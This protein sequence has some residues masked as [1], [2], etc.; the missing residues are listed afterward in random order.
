M[1]DDEVR[2]GT[3]VVALVKSSEPSIE[4]KLI[5]HVQKCKITKES[6][7]TLF[8]VYQKDSNLPI[9]AMTTELYKVNNNETLAVLTHH[10]YYS[11]D[12]EHFNQY[13]IIKRKFLKKLNHIINAI[14]NKNPE[15]T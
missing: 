1:T 10:F 2:Q 15:Q 9:R 4:E 14:S 12:K 3:I 8:Y 5:F 11:I 13:S 6:F 7:K